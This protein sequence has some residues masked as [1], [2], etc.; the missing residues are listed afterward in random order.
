MFPQLNLRNYYLLSI[1][2]MLRILF[3]TDSEL[4]SVDVDQLDLLQFTI[5]IN[6]WLEMNQITDSED[7]QFSPRR[8]QKEKPRN[9]SREKLKRVEEQKEEKS[10]PLENQNQEQ[11]SEKLKKP[12]LKKLLLYD[13]H[14]NLEYIINTN[15]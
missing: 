12:I 11:T 8:L 3:F 9:N 14:I 7:L 5:V 6:T 10:Q 2:G 4:P 15:I 1:N 13:S